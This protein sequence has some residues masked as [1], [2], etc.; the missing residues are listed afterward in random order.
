MRN[1]A[2]SDL[3]LQLTILSVAWHCVFRSGNSDEGDADPTSSAAEDNVDSPTVTR[4]FADDSPSPGPVRAC[5][6]MD[7][8]DAEV[9]GEAIASEAN[10]KHHYVLFERV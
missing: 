7:D 5:N 2:F 1:N 4:K 9:I 8:L 6:S 10:T 3:T